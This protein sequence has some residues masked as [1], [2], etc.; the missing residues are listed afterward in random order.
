MRAPSPS[1]AAE[2]RAHGDEAQ[3]ASAPGTRTLRFGSRCALYLGVV[4]L[5]GALA[6]AWLRLPVVVAGNLALALAFALDALRLWRVQLAVTRELELRMRVSSEARYTL[7]LENQSSV[8]LDVELR[9]SPPP[10]VDIAPASHRLKVP[11]GER[12]LVETTL[13][14]ERRGR[15]AF[16]DVFVRL[17]S[18]LKL[19]SVTLRV[20][21]AAELYVVPE[22]TL[23]R[24]SN[25]KGPR[26][27]MGNVAMRIRRASQGSELESLREYSPG[28]PL[29]AVDWKA[30]AKRRH[31]VT[32]LYQPERSQTIWFVLDASRTMAS[33]IGEDGSAEP[34]EGAGDGDGE[35]R[36][37]RAKTRFDVA[38]EALL[39]VAD[40]ALRAGDQV[41]VIVHGDALERVIPPG[42]G[43]AQY[44]RLVDMLAD[45]H[46]KRVQL[47]VRGLVSQLER[48]ARKRS[49]L[50][51][52]TDLENET[53]GE[54][55]Y[56]HAH[57]LT[58]RHIVLC[59]SLDDS[60]T[61]SLADAASNDGD[62]GVFARA[63]AIDVLRERTEL[64]RKLEK[65]NVLVL[66]ASEAGL[67]RATLDRYLDV[68]TRALL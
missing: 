34:G 10:G 51:L 13:I 67:A 39:V 8:S 64:T 29:R 19:A 6:P 68:K 31:P 41:G 59:V 57:V 66:A 24:K 23:E 15:S 45:V 33:T 30:T 5:V 20:P 58:R 22:A 43:R 12:A 28:D 56:D 32:R 53:H 61:R 14:A 18:G 35:Q 55:L 37:M 54:A 27:D 7:A 42:R 11:P 21:L 26:I 60:I 65:R 3:R 63:A 46:P 2:T 52:F 44:R 47:D 38:L 25:R 36:T 62:G 4:L 16:G 9:D 50:V 49:L 40:G 1:A 17:Q 48:R